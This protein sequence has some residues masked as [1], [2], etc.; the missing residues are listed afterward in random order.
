M[1][2]TCNN[3]LDKSE[4]S[5]LKN[6]CTK[7]TTWSFNSA[8]RKALD[9]N[10]FVNLR[11]LVVLP[12]VFE[13]QDVCLY[14]SSKKTLPLNMADWVILR[15]H[16]QVRTAVT[17]RGKLT[18]CPGSFDAGTLEALDGTISTPTVYSRNC[19]SGEA[20]H[21][22]AWSAAFDGRKVI[23]ACIL[24]LPG[25]KNFPPNTCAYP[26][27]NLTY[28][29]LRTLN[30][31]LSFAFYSTLASARNALFE[32][33]ADIVMTS[34]ITNAFHFNDFFFPEITQYRYERFYTWK[35]EATV[36][37]VA[38]VL[39]SW[40]ALL[41]VLAV[42]MVSLMALY[43]IEYLERMRCARFSEHSHWT[44]ILM[45]SFL[46]MPAHLP[47]EFVVN[48]R[49]HYKQIKKV[50]LTVWLLCVLPLCVYFRG[51]LTSSTAVIIPP[52]PVDTV[53]ELEAGLDQ[54][55]LRPCIVS[56]HAEDFLLKNHFQRGNQVLREKLTAAFEHHSGTDTLTFHDYMACLNSCATRPGFACFLYAMGDCFLKAESWPFVESRNE[57]GLAFIST[58]VR[59]DFSLGKQYNKVMRR[60]FETALN[61]YDF[62][63]PRWC[64]KNKPNLALNEDVDIIPPQRL[65]LY[66]IQVFLSFFLGKIL[67][68]VCVLCIEVMSSWKR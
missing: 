42:M 28:E 1:F 27:Y 22:S 60:I 66:D 36:S 20:P 4:L 68:C 13:W 8:F 16:R 5:L 58:P 6:L 18:V 17:Y 41:S 43:F 12:K 63:K 9:E 24:I 34:V 19:I 37:F 2:I 47:H 32:G 40:P 15:D 3:P 57:L 56:G 53:D 26:D 65:R 31:T 11:S 64:G 7:R 25:R 61:P 39:H 46:G 30:V 59:K 21:E 50:I 45:A 29:V 38:F 67:T 14:G 35:G 48:S 10:K 23:F 44:M 49:G 54:G 52:D 51:E 55:K 33:D 62:H